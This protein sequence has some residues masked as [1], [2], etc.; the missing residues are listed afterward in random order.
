MDNTIEQPPTEAIRGP[1]N[2]LN[3]PSALPS[4]Q[5]PGALQDAPEPDQSSNNLAEPLTAE[6]LVQN[7]QEALRE[8]DSELFA[9]K[10]EKQDNLEK[11]SLYQALVTMQNKQLTED[12]PKDTLSHPTPLIASLMSEPQKQALLQRSYLLTQNAKESKIS[13]KDLESR[14]LRFGSQLRQNR[15]R[16]PCESI[17]PQALV[18]SPSPS[19]LANMA[20]N[21]LPLV[22][23]SQLPLTMFEHITTLDSLQVIA[24]IL[25]VLPTVS[26]EDHAVLFQRLI[27]LNNHMLTN[28]MITHGPIHVMIAGG[29][30]QDVA[31]Y[32]AIN[33]DPGQTSLV[34]ALGC[35]TKQQ[36][37]KMFRKAGNSA[38][39]SSSSSS[40]LP[41][42]KQLYT[43]TFQELSQG[44]PGPPPRR[45]QPG[46]HWNYDFAR[47]MWRENENKV[48]KSS[49]E[50]Q[51][52]HKKARGQSPNTAAQHQ[53]PAATNPNARQASKNK[54]AKPTSGST[55]PK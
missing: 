18:T 15:D 38:T 52:Q 32:Q 40:I 25:S 54:W 42:P 31:T 34:N 12:K 47:S 35:T 48:N 13:T 29:T 7:L 24:A 45:A 1:E 23:R 9:L 30:Q 36:V 3:P 49:F 5:E 33:Q 10:A 21:A 11:V 22:N 27:T 37:E 6:Q 19:Q 51:S 4:N 41:V 8:Q 28:A 2:P 17:N 46:K 16:P 20:A 39:S 53:A 14:N 26:A 44:A 43:Q 50:F 55:A